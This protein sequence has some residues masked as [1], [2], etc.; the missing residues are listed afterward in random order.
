MREE[1]IDGVG[2]ALWDATGR[3]MDYSPPAWRN[4]ATEGRKRKCWEMAVRTEKILWAVLSEAHE[5]KVGETI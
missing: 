3:H 2:Y 5:R 1:G 4:P